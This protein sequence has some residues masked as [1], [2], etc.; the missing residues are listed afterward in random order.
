MVAIYSTQSNIVI[1]STQSNI[2]TKYF[3]NSIVQLATLTFR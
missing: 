3:I 1:Y 2:V